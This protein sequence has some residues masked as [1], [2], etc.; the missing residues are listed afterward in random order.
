MRLR[1][2]PSVCVSK[3]LTPEATQNWLRMQSLSHGAWTLILDYTVG[4]HKDY[5][6]GDL[7]LWRNCLRVEVVCKRVRQDIH[8]KIVQMQEIGPTR[9][10]L[11]LGWKTKHEIRMEVDIKQRWSVGNCDCAMRKCKQK[12][13]I[14]LPWLQGRGENYTGTERS[15]CGPISIRGERAMSSLYGPGRIDDLIS[16]KGPHLVVCSL[17]CWQ[18][19]RFLAKRW[20]GQDMRPYVRGTKPNSPQQRWIDDA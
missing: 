1:V 6:D 11:V 13:G 12:T 9:K 18:D 7:S 2:T 5:T 19:I 4:F 10:L 17:G 3:V 8:P 14:F 15:Y 16:K 20:P